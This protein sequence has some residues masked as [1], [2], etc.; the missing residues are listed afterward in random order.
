MSSP[1][2]RLAGASPRALTVD[3]I[4]FKVR[5]FRYGSRHYRPALLEDR[6]WWGVLVFPTREAM[7]AYATWRD[8]LTEPNFGAMVRPMHTI[9]FHSRGE[10]LRSRLGEMYFCRQRI[11]GS[12]VAHESLHAALATLRM[13][14]K[15]ASL[16]FDY[17]SDQ[18][19]ENEE[20]LC[21]TLGSIDRQI[22]IA[23]YRFGVW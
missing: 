3:A 18:G 8:F 12:V 9:T 16:H 4:R 7:Y 2:M 15:P 13:T 5:P 21:Y 1:S 23:L 11:G 10:R 17:D 6:H 22:A 20:R 19:L 14:A